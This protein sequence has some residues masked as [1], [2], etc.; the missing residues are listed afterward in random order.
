[1]YYYVK[2]L[3]WKLLFTTLLHYTHA[4]YFTTLH[5]CYVTTLHTYYGNYCLLLY[6]TTHLHCMACILLLL[7]TVYYVTTLHTCC[8]HAWLHLLKY[9]WFS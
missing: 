9:L 3:L 2:L 4:Y 7:I 6:Y 5:I 1:M 8:L